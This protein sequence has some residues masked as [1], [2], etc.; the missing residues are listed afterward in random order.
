MSFAGKIEPSLGT[1]PDCSFVIPFFNEHE[2]LQI[3]YRE[4]VENCEALGNTFELVFVDD[5]STDA[6]TEVVRR[7]AQADPRVSLLRF[8]RNFGK[9]AALSA[10]FGA[11]QGDVVFSMDADL[12]DNP[13]EIGNF[14]A[15][16][17]LGADVV[18][19]WKQVRNDPVD[20][21]LP[22]KLF[23]GAVNKAFGL[24]LNDHNCGFKAYRRETL[25]ELNLYGELHRFVPALLHA[26][27]FRIAQIP[28]EHRARRFG[29]SKFGAKR[30]VKGA[31]DLLTVWLTTRYG[32][33]PLH[34]F[35]GTGLVA[36]VLGGGILTYLSVLWALGMGPIG[37]RPLLLFGML[38]VLAGGQLIGVGLL[39]ELI[40]ARTIGEKDKYA[41]AEKSG[42]V[43]D[44][45]LERRI[46]AASTLD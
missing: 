36:S 30:L 44:R 9:S 12:Q 16:L 31:L 2:S 43:A 13:S 18:S 20:K 23:N 19:G 5:G 4:I 38:L 32:A 42:A 45:E 7:L 17:D 41:I 27:G 40:L 25:A 21:T 11:A 10:G 35:G 15:A 6:G 3:L 28:V 46:A 37:D 8:R 34:L 14:L 22:S 24:K 1:A 26:R 39:G 29:K 33:R